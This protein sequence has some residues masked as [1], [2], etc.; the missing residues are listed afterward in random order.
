M[1][2]SLSQPVSPACLDAINDPNRTFL[3]KRQLAA[4]QEGGLTSTARFKVI[5]NEMPIQQYYILPYDRWEGFAHR[6]R[7]S[8]S[9]SLQTTSRT[10]SS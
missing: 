3:G 4:L 2:P 10:W 8:C 1:T 7:R 5:M 9:D 6:A